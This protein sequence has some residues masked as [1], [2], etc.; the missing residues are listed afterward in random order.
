MENPP[1]LDLGVAGG[2]ARRKAESLRATREAQALE[3]HPR[4]GQTLLRFQSAP[5]AERNWSSGARGEELLAQ[6]L[7]NRCPDAVVLHD[8]M[9]PRSRAN[10]DHIAIA[11]SGVLVIDPKRYTGKITVERPIF[12]DAKLRIKGRDRTKLIE[13]LAR[14]VELVR[15][16]MREIAPQVPVSG[17]LCFMAPEG[18]L[19][20]SG[21]PLIRTLSMKG[22]PLLY[23]KRVA[24]RLNAPGDLGHDHVRAIASELALR[25]PAKSYPATA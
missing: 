21:L 24:K 7:A 22:Y 5:Q 10:I 23:P 18:F 13:G 12:G 19:A 11:P 9:I 1:E 15:A 16:A 4:I 6:I 8:R 20:E 25:F 3:R 17:C 2:S 14:Q